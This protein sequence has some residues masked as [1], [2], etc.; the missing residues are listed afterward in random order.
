MKH[1]LQ[2]I[3]LSLLVALP[4]AGCRDLSPVA[5]KLQQAET[6]M[7]EYPD[8]ALSLLKSIGQADL[9]SEEHRARYALLYSQALDKNYIDVT[10][11]SL[12]NIA[13]E[14]YK[15]KN[16]VR[17]KFLSYYYQGRIYTNANELTQSTLAYME[18]EQLVEELG[19]DYA[20]GLLYKQMGYIYRFYCDFPK[21]AESYQQAIENFTKADKHIHRIQTMFTLSGIHRNM[22]EVGKAYI[23]LETA[24]A[25]AKKLEDLSLVKSCIGNLIMVCIDMEQWEE[26]NRWYQEY[27]NNH[28]YKSMT[29]SFMAYIA[30]LHAK[31]R[32]FKEAF[33]FMDKA[34]SKAL[35][36]QDS[37][38]LHYTESQIH[39]MNNS[40]KQAYASL[41]KSITGQNKIIRNSLQQP[42][43]TVQKDFLNRELEYKAYKLKTEKYIRM[44]GFTILALVSAIVILFLRKK[45]RQYYRRRLKEKLLAWD[46]AHEKQIKDIQ[47]KASEREQSIQSM[48]H[49]LEKKLE[50]NDRLSSQ[51]IGELKKELEAAKQHIQESQKVQQELSGYIKELSQEK[52]ALKS[53]LS[54][55]SA[56][57]KCMEE[58][59]NTY[60]IHNN[61]KSKLLKRYFALMEDLIGISTKKFK[62]DKEK[63]TVLIKFH[64][65]SI[66]DFSGNKSTV[67]KLE[68]IV[69]ECNNDIMKHL[70]AEIDLPDETF[71]QLACYLYVGYSI[72]IIASAMGEST[73]TIYKRREK[74]RN[75]VKDSNAE[76]KDLFLQI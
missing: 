21:A 50:K 4:F 58:A 46:S 32:N 52:Q 54:N 27:I 31:N 15:D 9:Q 72:N 18:A 61:F 64:E 13:V 39:L 66:Q 12:I 41:E 48:V 19:D 69:N 67:A 42:I 71:Y 68:K 35:N 59:S 47:K 45:I 2:Y 38:N 43:L 14:Y 76:H 8:S 51:N 10:N 56:T 34:W 57:I 44:L 40:G 33:S 3:I 49:L 26:A 30:Q 25:E 62:N 53:E 6:C 20:A 29:V 74:I 5:E 22:N 1:L 60:L 73:N 36:L 70:R 37:I 55:Q 65:K 63:L 17:A 23:I 24:L 75:I 16:D 11:D 28:S 7:N